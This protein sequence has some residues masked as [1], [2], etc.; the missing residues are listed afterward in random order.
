MICF[1]REATLFGT[2]DAERLVGTEGDDVIRFEEGVFAEPRV[3]ELVKPEGWPR[4][5]DLRCTQSPRDCN[6]A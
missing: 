4:V 3:I 2:N 6:S 5:G 1:G